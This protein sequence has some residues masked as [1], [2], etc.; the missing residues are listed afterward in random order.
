MRPLD[1]YVRSR[2]LELARTI[3]H[4]KKVY[5]DLRFWIYAR[6]AAGDDGADPAK[7]KLL[8]LLRRGV[9]GGLIVCPI[10]ES[11][12]L[13][14]MK[15]ANTTTRRIATA[16]IIDELSLGVSFTTGR[17]RIATEIGHFF[18]TGAGH[19]NLY[20]M[21]E[22]VWTK[23]AYA[24]GYLHPSAPDLGE[25]MELSTQKAVFDE[26]WQATL[27]HMVTITG[28]AWK[29]D[30]QERRQSA[31]RIDADMKRPEHAT[32][33]Y[34]QTYR[35]EIVGAADICQDLAA[36]AMAGIAERA[37]APPPEKDSEAW[38]ET[39]RMCR[40]LIIAAFEQNAA[41]K[42]MLRTMH[43]MASLHA[44]MRWEK[45][46]KFTANHYYDFE[47]AAGALSYCDG[48][49]TEGFL[50]NLVNAKHTDLVGL[51]PCVTTANL[52]EAVDIL[53]RFCA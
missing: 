43:I 19:T 15:Q 44:G 35:D 23:L 12:F 1:H 22:L 26:L 50:S 53:R 29:P 24:M 52:D 30:D 16:R 46:A 33:S 47:H 27:T 3:Q 18:Y 28:D 31:A 6:E 41:T 38:R 42:T 34:Q 7:R 17:T 45:T 37:G 10:S 21:Q 8:H 51:N 14:V 40:N 20:D 49:F 13:E 32:V 2:Q 11:T 48:F 9:A 5:L 36:D 25:E 4:R 39:G